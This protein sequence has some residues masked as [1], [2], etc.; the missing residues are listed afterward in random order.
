MRIYNSKMSIN[1][2]SSFL[3]IDYICQ[4]SLNFA[5]FFEVNVFWLSGK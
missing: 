1:L 4:I 2:A 3:N 5:A